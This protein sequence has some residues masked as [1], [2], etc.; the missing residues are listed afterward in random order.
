MACGFEIEKK[1][2]TIFRA[3][4]EV[5]KRVEC[6]RLA[7]ALAWNTRIAR[8]LKKREQAPAQSKRW[9]EVAWAL[10]VA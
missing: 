5:A 7:G 6:V 3:G 10:A 4:L 2:D 1:V 9:R 8:T